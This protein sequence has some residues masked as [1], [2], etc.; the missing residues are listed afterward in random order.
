MQLVVRPQPGQRP[1]P[2]PNVVARASAPALG[3]ALRAYSGLANWARAA[4][5]DAVCGGVRRRAGAGR[6]GGGGLRRRRLYDRAH[7][8]QQLR[9]HLAALVGLAPAEKDLEIYFMALKA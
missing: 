3:A 1:R 8:R 9:R 2:H 6:A 7:A 4:A 5:H